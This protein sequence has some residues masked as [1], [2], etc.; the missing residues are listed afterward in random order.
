MRESEGSVV[1]FSS[2]K[3]F[4]GCSGFR[5]DGS[6]GPIILEFINAAY[7]F[8]PIDQDDVVL[9]Y[10]GLIRRS[11]FGCFRYQDPGSGPLV[12]IKK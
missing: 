12:K 2:R 9:F 7:L 11:P 8:S 5:T 3:V 10:P 6:L 4:S 1:G